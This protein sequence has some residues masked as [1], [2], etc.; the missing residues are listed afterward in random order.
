IRGP[1]AIRTM[2]QSAQQWKTAPRFLLLV[3]DASYDPRNYQGTNINI[4]FVPTKL[5]S[6]SLMKTASDDWLGDFNGDGAA[7][8]AVGRIPVQTAADAALVFNRLTSRGTPSGSW[9]TNATFVT[10]VSTDFDFGGT[11]ASLI[12]LLPASWTKSTI[13]FTTTGGAA[14]SSAINNGSILVDY[15][16]HGSSE[17][18]GSH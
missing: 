8:I 13:D 5:V 15:I 9:A 14:V 1:E 18:W 4:D 2:M 17:I 11:A 7:D 12:P 16:G 3:G 10:D 6:T